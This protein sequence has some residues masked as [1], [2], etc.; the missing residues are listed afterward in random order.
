MSAP[1]SI[2]IDIA[3]GTSKT[4][5]IIA[6]DQPDLTSAEIL[7][8]VKKHAVDEDIVISKFYDAT[9]STDLATG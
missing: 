3:Q 9:E 7:L 8:I 5:T 4:V 2:P 6:Q 1:R